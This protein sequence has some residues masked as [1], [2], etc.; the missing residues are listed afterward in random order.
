MTMTPE[1]NY[2]ELWICEL[3]QTNSRKMKTCFHIY[4]FGNIR[5]MDIEMLEQYGKG[6]CRKVLKIRLTTS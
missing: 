2:P 6:G 1:T 5:N 3:I 4:Y